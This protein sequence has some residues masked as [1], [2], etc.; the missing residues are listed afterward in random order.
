M[1]VYFQAYDAALSRCP[2]YA[3]AHN[4]IGV[5]LK[6]I[7]KL[8]EAIAAYK[9]CLEVIHAY[10]HAYIHAKIHACTRILGHKCFNLVRQHVE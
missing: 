10:G 4:N 7:G 6:S 3:E 2:A 1:P 5:L 9:K 8:P